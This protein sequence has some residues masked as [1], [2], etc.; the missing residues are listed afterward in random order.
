MNK[1][2]ELTEN[3]VFKIIKKTVTVIVVVYIIAFCTIVYLQ[4]FSNNKVSVFNFRMF[5]VISES[6]KPKYRIGDVLFAKEVDP[7]QIKV[8]D[9]ISY[10]GR[11]GDLRGK[12][13]TH[14]VIR[15][16]LEE[17]G[18]YT[19]HTRGLANI[20]EDPVVHEDQIYGKV[21]YKSPILSSIYRMTTTQVGFYICII[22]PLMIIAINEIVATLVEKEDRRRAALRKP[23]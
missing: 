8:G 21:V 20:I 12:I 1:L 22:M 13:V 23:E 10:E 18:K 3:K 9:D 16:I 19:F 4:R 2:K 14:Q 15:I 7:V 6:M 17:N 11:F 5:T